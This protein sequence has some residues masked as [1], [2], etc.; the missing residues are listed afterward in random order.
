MTG[1]VAEN[2]VAGDLVGDVDPPAHGTDRTS[3]G[4][5]ALGATVLAFPAGGAP[6]TGGGSPVDGALGAPNG[7]PRMSR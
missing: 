7:Q 1:R 2:P 4:R 3:V 6:V 5:P